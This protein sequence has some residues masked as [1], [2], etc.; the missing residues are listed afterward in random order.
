MQGQGSASQRDKSGWLAAGKFQSLMIVLKLL[1]VPKGIQRL[2]QNRG[3]RMRWRGHQAIVH[4]LAF[5]PRG[6]NSSASKV[7]EVPG[8]FRLAAL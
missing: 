5:S 6:H 1:I 3:A 7:S 8:D 4:P 2:L